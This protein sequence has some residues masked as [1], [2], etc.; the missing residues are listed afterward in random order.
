MPASAAASMLTPVLALAMWTFVVWVWMYATRIPAMQRLRIDAGKLK[1]SVDLD[2]L[3][4]SVKQVADNYNHL[5]EQPTTFYALAFY[6]H[7]TG[8]DDGVNIALAWSYVGVRVLHS[9]V[10]NTFNFVPARFAVFAVSSLIL[11]AIGVRSVLAL[12][13]P[14]A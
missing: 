6:C 10:Q 5:H 1:R 11:M 14:G 13:A 8:L 2:A 9:V 12:F 4:V 3:P 7:L